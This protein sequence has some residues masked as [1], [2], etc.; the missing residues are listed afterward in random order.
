MTTPST[1]AA[2]ESFQALADQL[3]TLCWLANPDGYITWYNRRWHEYCGTTP[4]VM[5]GWGWQSVHDPDVLPAVLDQW[6]SCIAT[7]TFFEMTFPLRGA[8]GVF[9]PFLTRVQPVSDDAG[10]VLRW[11]GVNIDVSAQAAAESDLKAKSDMLEILNKTGEVISADLDLERIVQS[12]TDAAV[13]LV[14]A[15][16][17]AFFYNV[18]TPEGEG[19]TLYALAGA[20]RAAFD[21]FGIPRA[22]AVFK[23][24]FDG[25]GVIRSD[26]ILMDPRYGK[27]APLKGMPRGHLPVRSYLAAPVISRSGEVIGGLFFGHPEPGRFRAEH[28]R[29]VLG[30]AS[31]AA[32]AIDNAR[33]YAA[34]QDEIR[35]REAAE[36]ALQANEEYLRL[37]LNSAA[38]GFYA[39]DGEGITTMVNQAFRDMLGFREDEAIGQKLHDRIHHTHPDGSPYPKDDCPIY[40]AAQGGASSHVAKEFFFRRDGSALPVEY[41]AHPLPAGAGAICVFADISDRLA[42]QASQAE[43]QARLE[44]EVAARTAERDSMWNLTQDLLAVVDRNG[45]LVAV[46]P[47]WESVLGYDPAELPGKGSLDLVHPEDA[48]A[49]AA[50]LEANRLQP[51]SNFEARFR[52]K[53]GSCRSITWSGTPRGDLIYAAGRDVTQ[54]RDQ[55][56]ALKAAE[57]ALRQVQKMEAVGQLTGGIAHDFNNMLAIIVGSLDIASRRLAKGESD[58]E[59]YLDHAREGAARATVLTQRLLAFSRQQPLA[60]KATD[61]NRLVSGM[62]ELLRRT[63]GETISLETILAGGLWTTFVDP[64]QLESTIVNLAVNARDA[65]PDGGEL[66]IETANAHLDDDYVA[67]NIGVEPGQYVIVAVTDSGTGISPEI[68]ERV[69]EPFFTTKPV[70]KG[71]GLGLSM[72]FGFVKQ[73]GGHVK[74]YSEPGHGTTLRLYLPRFQ[75]TA[76]HRPRGA[77]GVRAVPAAGKQER[78]MVVEDDPHVRRMS[79]QALE[80]LGYE[81]LEAGSGA[82]AL[83]Q[84]EAGERPELLFTDVVMAGLTGRELADRVAEKWPE[85]KILYT[86]GYTRNA[87]VH[88]GVLE[89]GL[90]LIPKPF[91]IADLAQKVRAVLDSG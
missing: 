49:A 59:R 24:T 35:H 37:I 17:G 57:D 21:K 48:A 14:G 55:A 4:E 56:A 33:L 71:T 58:I 29:L 40:R 77:A 34:A 30:V 25:E 13:E 53:D 46:N 74:I 82:E 76:S 12:V 38:V 54:E 84:L 64:H 60:P 16:F 28:E 10:E 36:Q 47:A 32:V 63:L 7:G 61:C 87:V 26:D 72:V 39:V 5:E 41:W 18:L 50:T 8:D 89:P 66:T 79:V 19:L 51:V 6:R 27:N 67:G 42:A 9:R 62:S 20:D 22:T 75:G 86:T 80:D 73:S 65:M 91:S 90:A 11:L 1:R 23:P 83:A 44:A 3:P 2:D 88:N 68:M 43:F 85:I 52:H 31:Q 78:I 70:G 15:Q 45:R 69:F 81:V